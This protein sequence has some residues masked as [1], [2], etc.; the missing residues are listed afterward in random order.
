[1][2]GGRT[3]A[4]LVERVDLNA[5]MSGG[6]SRSTCDGAPLADHGHD[7]RGRPNSR[8]NSASHNL[9]QLADDF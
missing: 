7:G 3:L 1:V 5:L 2:S 9:Q 6:D 8:T 4:L